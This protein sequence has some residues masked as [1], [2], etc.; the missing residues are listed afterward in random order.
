ME[1]L[2]TKIGEL[3]ATEIDEVED[4]E[5]VD[6]EM[7]LKYA[8]NKELLESVGIRAMEK[9]IKRRKQEQSSTT[10]PEMGVE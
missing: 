8:K 9:E 2:L 10:I 5:Y 1:E 6:K 4:V 3:V 7:D